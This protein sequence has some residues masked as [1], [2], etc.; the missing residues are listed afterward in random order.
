VL[1][2][3][4][5]LLNTELKLKNRHTWWYMPVIPALRRL[6]EENQKFEAKQATQQDTV[7][8][9]KRVKNRMVVC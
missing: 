3:S 9:R 1:N 5:N 7:S 4:C 6:R 2:I 8:E